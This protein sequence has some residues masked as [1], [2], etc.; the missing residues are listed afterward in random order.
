M[1]EDFQLRHVGTVAGIIAGTV[2]FLGML[3]LLLN[4]G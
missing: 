3:G 1:A 4:I 2:L